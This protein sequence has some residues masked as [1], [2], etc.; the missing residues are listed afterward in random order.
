MALKICFF[1]MGTRQ[2]RI[3]NITVEYS[4]VGAHSKIKGYFTIL[5]L[6]NLVLYFAAPAYLAFFTAGESESDWNLPLCVERVHVTSLQSACAIIVSKRTDKWKA[7]SARE[8]PLLEIVPS[9]YKGN[10]QRIFPRMMV[11]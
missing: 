11:H 9:G 3:A 7:G 10:M 4:F 8:F 5:S 6:L 2:S 1:L